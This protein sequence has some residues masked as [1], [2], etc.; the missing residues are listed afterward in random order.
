MRQ[1]PKSLYDVLF[2][3]QHIRKPS[4]IGNPFDKLPV[5]E[6]VI[7]RGWEKC[8]LG[9]I[10]DSAFQSHAISECLTKGQ[11]ANFEPLE[12]RKEEVVVQAACD[13]QIDELPLAA[14]VV[15]VVSTC[16]ED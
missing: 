9:K 12:D 8:R 16:L 4:R 6:Q 14:L 5:E 7:R 2:S 15:Q 3:L 13:V 1:H 10:H 11:L